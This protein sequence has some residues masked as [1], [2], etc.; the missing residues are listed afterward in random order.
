MRFAIG[1]QI[2]FHLDSLGTSDTKILTTTA[3]IVATARLGDDTMVG[4]RV[5]QW[6][7]SKG[8][9]RRGRDIILPVLLYWWAPTLLVDGK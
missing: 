5:L 4:A 9:V 6:L 2:R 1:L 3:T 7:Q 8:V